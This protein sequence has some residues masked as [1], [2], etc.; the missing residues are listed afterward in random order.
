M[1]Y[2]DQTKTSRRRFLGGVG[3]AIGA[4]AFEIAA[5]SS[6]RGQEFEAGPVTQAVITDVVVVGSGIAGLTAALQAQRS[7]AKVVV[8]EKASEPGGTTAHSNGHVLHFT[9]EEMRALVPEGDAEVQRTVFENITRWDALMDELDA[10][11]GAL[12]PIP[13]A[14]DQTFRLL[15][16]TAWVQF[17]IG[18][19]EQGRGK[20][21]VDTPFIRLLMSDDNE[22]VGVLA[23]SPRGMLHIRAKAVVLAT[24]GWMINAMLVQG[25]ITRYF[26][27]LRQRN[28]SAKPG[29]PPFLGDG[30]FAA[31]EVGGQPSTGGFDSFYGHLAP[32]EPAVVTE[33]VENYG[34]GWGPFGLA[35]NKLGRR[36][37]DESL[38]KLSGRKLN[39]VNETLLVQEVARQPD[40]M[41]AYVCDDAI[42]KRGGWQNS[43]SFATGDF[44][45]FK[46]VG[47]PVA[48][49]ETLTGL[50]KQMEGWGI[51]MSAEATLHDV[52]EYNQAVRNG[53][54]WSLPIPKT[55]ARHALVLEKPPFYALL[56]QAG[57]IATHG[58]I[59]VNS[60][61]QVL[62]RSGQP[63][64]GLYAAGVDIGNFNN[65]A[66]IGNLNLGAAYG[67]V[68]GENAATQPQPRAGWRTTL[69]HTSRGSG[70]GLDERV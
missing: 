51:G 6:T 2:K 38:G 63:I 62:H 69:G 12:R 49:A 64:P 8:L 3:A 4:A 44:E 54:A 32:A 55:S 59:R 26:G 56:G 23:H 53:R 28:A 70:S 40:A 36:F 68:S 60:R 30:L 27:G 1:S 16:C 43:A 31:L 20:V 14:P 11:V 50:A 42:Y 33:P 37:A 39:N 61:G 45:R 5:Y 34:A 25:H 65:C 15:A 24:G 19:I 41:A 22:T 58:G 66:Y 29:H 17:M 21:M 7:G 47:A 46:E 10:P 9:Y 57:I 67:I 13:G 35:V 18:L 52:T 48:K